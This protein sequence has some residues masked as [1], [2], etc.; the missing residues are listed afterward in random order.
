MPDIQVNMIAVLIAVVAN[1]FLGFFW[2]S[3]LFKKAWALEMGFDPNEELPKKELLKSLGLAIIGYFLLAYVL[4]HQVAVW[5]SESW[6]LGTSQWSKLERV[7][8]AAF[9]TWLGFFV[10]VL[11]NGVAWAKQSWKLFS[12]NASYHLLAL[13]IVSSIL[14]YMK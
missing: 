13:L 8:Q 1:F 10:P 7:V 14:I 11:L 9:F 6:G 3:V 5:D 12:I 2:F 4:S